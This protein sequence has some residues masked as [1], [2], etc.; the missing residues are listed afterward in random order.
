MRT[1]PLTLALFTCA[2]V[3]LAA[4]LARA[5]D[6]KDRIAAEALF[7][8][9]T[10]LLEQGR[11]EQACAKFEASQALDAG[12]GTLLYLG[13]CYERDGRYASA[14]ATFREAESLARESGQTERMD[15]ARTRGAALNKRLSKIS[16][17]VPAEL[18]FEGLTVTLGGEVL[19]P[20]TYG[21]ALP[22]DPGEHRVVISAP[23][24]ETFQK[25]VKVAAGPG[26]HYRVVAPLLKPAKEQENNSQRGSGLRTAGLVTAGAGA[27]CMGAGA[28]LGVMAIAKNDQSYEECP[29]SPDRCT[30]RGT[31]LRQQAG[32]YADW[33][34]AGFA[35]GGGLIVTGLVL[36]VAAPSRAPKEKPATP[37][38]AELGVAPSIES[39]G[40]RLTVK[41]RF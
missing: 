40:L 15:V 10:A 17:V 39:R 18:R 2:S 27:V 3:L 14:W 32:E 21:D 11:Y 35:V 34:T 24:R 36:Y 8:Q 16:I 12:V 30:P 23:G 28:A 4:N 6:N 26:R 20:A 5:N 22:I 25:T 31:A 33:A 29:N 19:A 1:N 7:D 37:R 41:G 13:D 38:L 9:G